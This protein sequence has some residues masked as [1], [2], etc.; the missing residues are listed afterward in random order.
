MTTVERLDQR[1][2]RRTSAVLKRSLIIAGAVSVTAAV[3]AQAVTR[4]SANFHKLQTLAQK[5]IENKLLPTCTF[6]MC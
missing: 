6:Y 5:Q 1:L 2:W 3:A 4:V